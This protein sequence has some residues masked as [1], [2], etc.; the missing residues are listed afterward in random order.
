MTETNDNGQHST[1]PKQPTGRPFAAGHDPRRNGGGRPQGLARLAREAVGDGQDLIQF[2][3]AVLRADRKYLGE[4][5]VA[6]RDRMQAA[7]WLADRAFGKAIQVVEIPEDPQQEQ[8][9]AA[10]QQLIEMPLELRE[11]VGRWLLERRNSRLRAQR[12]AI[13]ARV[14]SMLPPAPPLTPEEDGAS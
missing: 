8:V 5:R 3:T 10:R 4:R 12:E 9:E 1:A 2:F 13:E 11:A 14:K 6:L 7:T